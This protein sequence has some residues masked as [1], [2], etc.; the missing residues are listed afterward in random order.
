MLVYLNDKPAAEGGG[1]D[2]PVL[3]IT[4]QPKR[5]MAVIWRNFHADDVRVDQRGKHAG[6]KILEGEKWA[7]ALSGWNRPCLREP[8]LHF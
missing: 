3:G 4:V 7:V 5:C 1:T 8:Y 6:L 2:F